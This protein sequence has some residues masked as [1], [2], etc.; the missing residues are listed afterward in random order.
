MGSCSEPPFL[1]HV[2]DCERY[3]CAHTGY[4][5]SGKSC[6]EFLCAQF[7]QGHPADT[8]RGHR[9]AD[10]VRPIVFLSSPSGFGSDTVLYSKWVDIARSA[11]ELGGRNAAGRFLRSTSDAKRLESLVGE[12]SSSISNAMVSLRALCKVC[13]LNAG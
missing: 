7:R 9:R 2:E 13:I 10:G 11:T 1:G 12:I 5:Q 8:A 3:R 4:Q 6:D